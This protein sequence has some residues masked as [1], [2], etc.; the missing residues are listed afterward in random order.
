MRRREFISLLVSGAAAWPLVSRAQQPDQTHRI[1]V[2]MN[3]REDN[4]EGRDQVTAFQQALQKLGWSDGRNV[5]IDIC[6]G[7]N[8]VDRERRCAT[9]LVALMPDV[10]LA[11]GTLGAIS[12]QH[13]RPTLPIVFVQIADPVGSGIVDSL[14][15]P[16]GN[17]T[18]FMNYEFSI[19][20][21]W[22]E[23]LKQIAPNVTRALV[24]R[25]SS[26]HPGLASSA[27]SRV[28]RSRTEWR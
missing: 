12:L 9:E 1:G 17:V 8:E 19:A 21:K 15:R 26:I 14:A 13:I 6:W 24:I 2:L 22:V 27:L 3:R 7:E 18:G 11:S 4:R 25:D 23:L 28:Q 16:G 10:V 5:R 20:G